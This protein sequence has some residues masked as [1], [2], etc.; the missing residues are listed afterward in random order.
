MI[1]PPHTLVKL[2][3]CSRWAKPPPSPLIPSSCAWALMSIFPVD[4][5]S[6]QP[7]LWFVSRPCSALAWS[8][9]PSRPYSRRLGLRFVVG[10]LFQ[11]ATVSVCYRGGRTRFHPQG[12][13]LPWA[14][15]LFWGAILTPFP[16]RVQSPSIPWNGPCFCPANLTQACPVNTRSP[17]WG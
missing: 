13:T 6:H 1:P 16:F 5:W 3:S 12:T 8:A 11:Q 10:E 15:K 4:S 9:T 14:G 2:P 7:T 17:G